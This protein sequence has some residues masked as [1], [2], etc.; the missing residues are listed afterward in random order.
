MGYLDSV[1][2]STAVAVSIPEAVGTQA[3]WIDCKRVV[4]KSWQLSM[5]RSQVK[6]ASHNCWKFVYM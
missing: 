3:S 2:R 4:K 5:I 1:S 6:A